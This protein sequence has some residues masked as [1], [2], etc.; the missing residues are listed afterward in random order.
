MAAT[1]TQAVRED[2]APPAT[3]AAVA[4]PI[5]IMAMGLWGVVGSLLTYGVVM[6]AIKAAAL[7]G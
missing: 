5:R 3:A 6:T 4:A 2:A 7:F 1:T